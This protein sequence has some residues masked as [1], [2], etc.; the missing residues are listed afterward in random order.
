MPK[1]NVDEVQ[2]LSEP[3]EV[4]LDGKT[5]AVVKVSSELMDKVT[6]LAKDKGQSNILPQQMGMLLGV[7]AS[8]FRT[9]DVRK[10]GQAIKFITGEITK[11]FDE[12]NA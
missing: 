5:Y 11:G 9:T 12:K 10:L 8:E 4:T 1:F 6:E 7:D 2:Q 3:I